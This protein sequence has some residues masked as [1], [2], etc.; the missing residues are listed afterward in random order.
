MKKTLLF[1]L[2]CGIFNVTDA[3]FTGKPIYNIRV[4]RADTLMGNII[5]ELFPNIA[6]LHVQNWDSIVIAGGYDSTAFHRIVP[7]FVIQGG[8]PN[9]I[10]GPV[11]TWGQ[12]NPSQAN[13]NA[14]F[15][16][17]PH[18][19]GI[20][21]AAR[22]TD[23]NSA[24]SQ[25]FICV[26]NAFSLD[27]NYSVY[28]E[29]TSGMDIVD[30]I[31]ASPVVSGTERPI[32]KIY[33]IIT[34]IGSNDSIPNAPTLISPVD[35]AENISHSTPFTWGIVPEAKLYLFEVAT[36]SDFTN[37]VY[38][39]ETKNTSATY[40]GLKES[41]S[42]YFWRVRTNNG[43]KYS[44]FDNSRS[45]QNTMG[46]PQLLTPE[47]GDSVSIYTYFDWDDVDQSTSYRIQVAKTS[48]FLNPN[49]NVIDE[50]VTSSNYK[51]NLG[52]DI[53]VMH[54]WRVLAQNDTDIGEYSEVFNFF[55]N[56]TNSTS[57]T[58]EVDLNLYPNPVKN[59]LYVDVLEPGILT[60]YDVKGS[61]IIY[62]EVK[63]GKNQIDVKKLNEGVFTIQI[64]GENTVYNAKF[65]K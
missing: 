38:S 62:K 36:D 65:I 25:Y 6:P 22:A 49:L 12:G 27:R 19:R 39:R 18:A 56:N 47:K 2:L 53:N 45:F 60:V 21:S 5:V 1:I 13:I 23:I 31:V 30:E 50:I 51:Y 44:T 59:T 55:P 63:K 32:E 8:D 15:S 7:G 35:N 46:V 3:Q 26:A 24:S 20:L 43:G 41:Y 54:Y 57:S 16:E 9:S 48:G 42:T 33:V 14:E 58:I 10:N 52:L 34:K 4:E 64:L 11:S 61:I 29:V 40:T 37:I 17:V 28:G